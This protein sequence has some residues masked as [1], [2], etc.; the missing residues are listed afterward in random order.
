MKY[1]L[2]YWEKESFFKDID[3]AI[4]G[5]GIVGLSAAIHLKYLNRKHR[6]VVFERGALPAGA[7]TRNAGFACFGSMTEILDDLSHMSEDEVLAVVEKRWTGLQ[8]LRAMLGDENIEFQQAGGYE[9][10]TVAEA[11]KFKQC[12]ERI[13]ELNEKLGR[14][15]NC[16]NGYQIVDE[17]IA[18]FGFSGIEHLILN[19]PEGQVNTGKMMSAMLEKAKEKGVEIFNG[20]GVQYLEDENST[21]RLG[22][23]AGWEINAG[24]VIVA[25]NGFAKQLLPEL[26]LYPA[27]NQVLLTQPI[28][29]LKV[30]GCFHYDRGYFY[31]RNIGDRILLGG[32]R[33]LDYK[34][35]ETDGFGS[36]ELI[37]NALQKLLADVIYPNK[38]VLIDSWWTGIMGLGSVKKPILAKTSSNVVAAVRMNGM[39]VAIGT[40]IGQEAAELVN[41]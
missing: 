40:L 25:V 8:R 24:R 10:F 36:N 16:K 22:T 41:S 26:D 3:F 35:E 31:F 38:P 18:E 2:S 15:T 23:E 19:S 7:S 29:N 33:N 34:T 5:S 6:V 11:E 27:R 37:R 4:I 39:G 30:K 14:I 13:P 28:Q 21:V 1:E 20:I 9:M 32:G 17:R 12:E